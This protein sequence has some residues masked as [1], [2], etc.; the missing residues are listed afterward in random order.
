MTRENPFP[1]IYFGGDYNPDQWSE[2][3]WEEDMRLFELA[4]V[5]MVTLPVFSWAKIQ[6]SEDEFRFEWLDRIL[7][8]LAS[9]GISACLA[10]PTA[11]QPAWMSR[12]YPDILPVDEEGRKRTHGKRVNYCPNSPSYRKFSRGIALRMAE[13]Y[14]AH[15][16]LA[17][18][19][20]SNEY[21]TYCFCDNCAAAF[22]K[23]LKKR[24]A[25]VGELNRRWNLDFWGHLIAD[26]EEIT[27]PSEL[28][29]DNKWYQP[30]MLDYLRF[31][32]DSTIDCF[33]NEKEAILSVSSDIPVTTNMSGFIKK[34]NQQLF[35]EHM[36]YAAWDNYPAPGA[37]PSLV[38]LKHDIV[39]GLKGGRSYIM[40]EQSPNQQNWQ[41]FNTLK[42]PGEVR[43]LSYQA[44]AHGA[45]T[46]LFFQMRQSVGGV[47]KFHG[48]LIEHHG[49]ENTRVFRE[50][51]ALGGE[52]ERLGDVFTGGTTEAKAALLVD[53]E[54][55]WALELST[56]PNRDTDYM[57]ILHKYYKAFYGRNI[58]VDVIRPESDLSSYS[59]VAVP[60]LYM[61]KPGVSDNLKAYTKQG[62]CLVTGCFSG[63]VDENDLVTTKGFPGEMRDLLGIWVEEFDALPPDREN[64]IAINDPIGKLTGTYSCAH[65]FDLLHL[66]SAE[67]LGTY[68][69]D[70]YKGRP[71]LTV[72]R[73]G[74][75]SAY[76]V[77][78][79]P[80][81]ALLDDLIGELC[82]QNG[83]EAPETVP[84]G[85]EVTVRKK[86]GAS[87]FFFMN[88]GEETVRLPLKGRKLLVGK[89][90]PEKDGLRIVLPHGGVA[91]AVEERAL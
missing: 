62:G 26:W 11:A 65:L 82:R 37:E 58:L 84:A 36:D 18:W 46:V 71:S 70:F 87:C 53:W 29:D 12:N 35:N 22:R 67:A 56:G 16:A 39:R 72:N 79:D 85:V 10:T 27:V 25:T 38:A 66:E 7:D 21:G 32:T 89:I 4:H 5:N 64:G 86:G 14:R 2:E 43:L 54:N 50:C 9:R 81:Q 75:G 80:E 61:V 83:V 44:L 57:A 63:I 13:R 47:E 24:Y 76:Y 6:P 20:I 88:H 68:T 49:A 77:A 90:L 55:W 15:P 42:R 3:V 40:M 8:L 59:L 23:W 28:N 73:Y 17:I 60:N 30:K 91:I 48:A 1:R 78:T 52:L 69:D 74:K 31:L 41:P 19:H 51:A 45:D 34:M 33:N